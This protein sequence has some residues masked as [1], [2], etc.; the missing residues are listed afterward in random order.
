MKRRQHKKNLKTSQRRA[1]PPLMCRGNRPVTWQYQLDTIEGQ[2][3]PT[4]SVTIF[5]R[6]MMELDES[7]ENGLERFAT[8][9]LT[10]AEIAEI[11]RVLEADITDMRHYCPDRVFI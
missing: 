7:G 2:E 10:R 9:T 11:L 1:F 6:V 3:N 5:S 8:V 4:N